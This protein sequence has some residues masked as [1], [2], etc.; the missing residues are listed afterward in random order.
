MA[1]IELGGVGHTMTTMFFD[2]EGMTCSACSNTVENG[3][4]N[5][6]AV[7]SVQV[8][9]I[10]EKAEVEFDSALMS[11]QLIAGEIEDLG[12]GAAISKTQPAAVRSA[13]ARRG[14]EDGS[15]KRFFDIEGMT[16]S[17]CSGAIENAL[18]GMH[19]VSSCLVSL[20]TNRAEVVFDPTVVTAEKIAQEV[21]DIGFG[22][23]LVPL[24]N[25]GAGGGSGGSGKM[26]NRYFTIELDHEMG[27]DD[28]ARVNRLLL[29]LTSVISVSFYA[30]P[31][32]HG[33]AHRH[34]ID[35]VMQPKEDQGSLSIRHILKVLKE[36]FPLH[37]VALGDIG[38]GDLIAR[39]EELR[40][41]QA[42]DLKKYRQAFWTS[43][44]FTVPTFFLS[45][46][47]PMIAVFHTFLETPV[48]GGL[49]LGPVL[50]ALLVT[51]VQFWIGGRFY[52]SAY[53]SLKHGSA[54]MDVLVVMGSTSAYVYSII[55]MWL[56]LLDSHYEGKMFFETSAMLISVI[57]LGKYFEH[58]AKGRTS[59][60]LSALMNL[61]ASEA[62]VVTMG[63]N[64][65]IESKESVDIKLVE[66]GDLVLV[67]ANAKVPV[68]GEVIHGSA[69]V[70]E[71][72]VTGEALPVHK[73]VGSLLIG[74]TIC[75]SGPVIMRATGVGAQTMLAQ[76]V[77]MVN[78]AQTGKAP[79]QAYADSVSKYFVPF[80][81]LMSL[82]TLVVWYS[83][84]L[85][86][87]IPADWKPPLEGDFLFSFLFAVAVM[88]ISCPCA[89]GLATPTAVMV[90]TGVGA[91]LGI[92]FKGGG[93]LE[94]TGKATTVLFDKTGTL[95]RGSPSV[96][97]PSCTQYTCHSVKSSNEFWKLVGAVEAV[98]EHLLARAIVKFAAKQIA[99]IELPGCEDFVTVGGRGVKGR[100]EGKTVFVGNV[101]WM[102]VNNIPVQQE[103]VRD[104]YTAQTK[105]QICVVVA[106][107]GQM[108]GLV[109]I[110][111]ILKPEAIYVIRRLRNKDINV[112]M[113]TGDH[114]RAAQTIGK[115]L[116][117]KPHEIFAQITPSGKA[118]VIKQFQRDLE[119]AVDSNGRSRTPV[120]LFVGDGVNDSPALAQADVG[121]AIGAG[122]AI[123]VET[124]QVVL[125]RP[126]LTDICTAI[127]LSQ[128]TLRRIH[129]NY[130]W[131]FMYNVVA[132]PVAMG[133]FYPWVHIPLPPVVAALAMG[134]S[135]VS[136]V[137]SSLLLKRYQR[138]RYDGFF[139][140]EG[141]A[142]TNPAT[143][144]VA[145]KFVDAL[146]TI[147]RNGSSGYAQVNQDS[148]KDSDGGTQS[149]R[150]RRTSGVLNIVIGARNPQH[151][152]AEVS[153]SCS[154]EEEE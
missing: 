140:L 11:P 76:I 36:N 49:K 101:E 69:Q 41:K 79:I 72:L 144:G 30:N 48:I 85:S 53:K 6:A 83:L 7:K 65:T 60:A 114:N 24:T 63:A 33:P 37:G 34:C 115:Q 147:I 28:Q 133:A 16:C 110:T 23:T 31:N 45:M 59:E 56:C 107:D 2:I 14:S 20:M 94:V 112:G 75:L 1:A 87:R 122:T 92:L 126:D 9:L 104:M 139:A 154:E 71:S 54:N 123:A 86:G 82:L 102:E 22:A 25:K 70:D 81:L 128:K 67:T 137:C 150:S 96:D 21:E 134:L 5:L 74:S 66:V 108:A 19:G 44:I 95:T 40:T 117:L 132:I 146:G 111:D 73:T 78:Q 89:L 93:P 153:S 135:S 113:V 100:V 50:V 64:E 119:A 129:M 136:V 32:G 46:V 118:D 125:T 84:C 61:Q 43:M 103:I 12:F 120:V 39:K 116:G 15:V 29:G 17:A 26:E 142:V 106:V 90:G 77:T 47:C 10:M 51:P 8:S 62:V 143:Q 57:L 131:A 145:G 27:A 152:A 91:Q 88:V 124:A 68:D 151:Q 99:P 52:K 141:V 109:V 55:N 105:G 38:D 138:P 3:L 127:D 97:F 121:V 35:L 80:V 148:D 58:M 4:K 42:L 18:N 13:M 130:L 98:S 149:D